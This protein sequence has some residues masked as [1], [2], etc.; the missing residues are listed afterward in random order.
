MSLAA[1]GG[2]ALQSPQDGLC[3]PTTHCGPCRMEAIALPPVRFRAHA[4]AVGSSN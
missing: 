3:L 2:G 1:E 4:V